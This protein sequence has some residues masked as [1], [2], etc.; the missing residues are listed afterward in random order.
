MHWAK[1]IQPL[2][3]AAAFNLLVSGVSVNPTTGSSNSYNTMST[4]L[5][6]SQLVALRMYVLTY[7]RDV[8][9]EKAWCRLLFIIRTC[10]LAG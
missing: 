7:Q 1:L 2:Y 10:V 4:Y 8:V 3:L 5:Y 9:S 6:S